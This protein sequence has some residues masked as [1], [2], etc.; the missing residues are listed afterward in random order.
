[1]IE[2][3]LSSVAPENA[4]GSAGAK[5]IAAEGYP[6]SRADMPGPSEKIRRTVA[7]PGPGGELSDLREPVEL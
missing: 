3:R 1:M 4:S 2:A 6:L 7:G 5:G